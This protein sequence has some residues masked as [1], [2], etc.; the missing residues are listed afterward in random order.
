MPRPSCPYRIAIPTELSIIRA[1]YNYWQRYSQ[2][3]ITCIQNTAFCQKNRI[4]RGGWGQMSVFCTFRGTS[5]LRGP[6]AA[7]CGVLLPTPTTATTQSRN[8]APL[9]MCEMNPPPKKKL[10]PS[11][12]LREAKIAYYARNMFEA[13]RFFF[14][15]KGNVT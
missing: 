1:S 4:Q 12:I 3:S 15:R 14:F 9:L 11:S 6:R 10:A 5:D 2:I 13:G 7:D 8:S